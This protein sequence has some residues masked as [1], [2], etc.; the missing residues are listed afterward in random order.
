MGHTTRIFILLIGLFLSLQHLQG[1][2]PNDGYYQHKD[3]T[4]SIYAEGTYATGQR[5]GE[6]KF[7]L[8]PSSRTTQI[9]DVIGQYEAGKK[10]GLWKYISP[11]THH[12]IQANFVNDQMQ[13]TCFYYDQTKHVLA[14]GLVQNGVRTGK[15]IFYDENNSTGAY[16]SNGLKLNHPMSEG[17]YEQGM[18]VGVW[19]YDYYMDKNTH[20][21]GSLHFEGSQNS[22]RFDFYKVERH[23]KFGA[24]E[25]LV[26]SGLY[27]DGKK[28]GRWI[29]FNHGTKGDFIETGDYDNQGHRDGIWKVR[30]NHQTYLAGSYKNGV[31]HGVFRHYYANGQLKYESTYNNGLEEGV[32]RHYYDNGQL[33]EQGLH[34]IIGD[35]PTIDTTF[36]E[37][38][39]PLEHHFKL[40]DLPMEQFHYEYITWLDQAGYSIAPKELERR[41]QLFVAHGKSAQAPIASVQIKDKKTVRTGEYLAFYEDGGLKMRGQHSPNTA[42]RFDPL[43]RK[44]VYG[45]ARDGEWKTYS[46]DKTL[47]HTYVYTKGKLEKML[48]PNGYVEHTFQYENG[49]VSMTNSTGNTVEFEG[50]S[51]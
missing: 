45:F 32:F 2:T 38:K 41:F 48:D 5:T 13:G 4:G 50:A 34:A 27:Q 47:Q 28:I 22:G 30:I 23:E 14:Q 18:R 21:K 16:L 24:E 8:S 40:V 12:G 25:N 46:K 49:T 42:H 39:L 37:I 20:V 6:W 3:P 19:E 35:E 29:E 7:Y 33:K 26:G 31:P 10:M 11:K 51:K 1:Q 44:M 43:R 17:K 36:L 15:W 9:P